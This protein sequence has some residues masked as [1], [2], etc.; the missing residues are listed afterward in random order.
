MRGSSKVACGWMFSHLSYCVPLLRLHCKNTI[1]TCGLLYRFKWRWRSSFQDRPQVTSCRALRIYRIGMS[2][3]QQPV[4]QFTHAVKLLLLK[5]FISWLSTT[6]MDKFSREFEDLHGIPYVVVAVDDSHI[7]IVAPRL[8]AAD[9]YN[10][11]RF[12]SILLHGVVSSKCLF[13]DFDIGWVGSMH[14]TN[15][16]GRTA[17]G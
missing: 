14:D 4:N 15:L 8:H 10:R 2:T 11:K 1:L 6:T 13:W 5:K 16:W 17:I 7:L 3:I 12:H 9:Y